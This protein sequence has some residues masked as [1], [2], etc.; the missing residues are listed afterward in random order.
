MNFAVQAE[1]QGRRVAVDVQL[2]LIGRR[3]GYPFGAFSFCTL[4]CSEGL[5]AARTRALRVGVCAGWGA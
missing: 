5:Y 3:K 1:V 4:R 2:L